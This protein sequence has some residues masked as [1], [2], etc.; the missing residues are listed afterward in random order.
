MILA[1][2]LFGEL[3]G[4][5]LKRNRQRKLER[6][7]RRL[8]A[9]GVGGKHSPLARFAFGRIDGHDLTAGKLALCPNAHGVRVARQREGIATGFDAFSIAPD[10]A[11]PGHQNLRLKWNPRRRG[12]GLMW[13]IMDHGSV[14]AWRASSG[15]RSCTFILIQVS[16]AVRFSARIRPP[17]SASIDFQIALKSGGVVNPFVARHANVVSSESASLG[18]LS[19]SL[20]LRAEDRLRRKGC[21]AGVRQGRHIVDGHSRV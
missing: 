9:L 20:H 3:A 10:D 15:K 16:F 6:G 18:S 1:A 21:E 14:A 7:K 19:N 13:R 17:Q 2:M 8:P 11:P 4:R 12:D 5:D